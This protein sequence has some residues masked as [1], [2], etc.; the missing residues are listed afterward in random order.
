MYIRDALNKDIGYKIWISEKPYTLKFF[1]NL[2]LPSERYEEEP[3]KSPHTLATGK[4]MK[5]GSH[6]KAIACCNKDLKLALLKN[7]QE[8]RF[9]GC[10]IL[11]LSLVA[12]HTGLQSHTY[13]LL[14]TC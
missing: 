8:S 9:S 5:S 7:K 10:E 12:L 2:F 14:M 3:W 6:L 13:N 11:Q 4:F 1:N